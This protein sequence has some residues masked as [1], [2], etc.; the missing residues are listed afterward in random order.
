VANPNRFL[1]AFGKIFSLFGPI[2]DQNSGKILKISKNH[3]VSKQD[4]VAKIPFWAAGWPAL[5]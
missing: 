3:R 4:W 1:A 2:F 5:I